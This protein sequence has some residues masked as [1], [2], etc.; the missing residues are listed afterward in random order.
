MNELTKEEVLHVAHLARIKLSDEEIK[1]YQK[2]LKV[3]MDQVDKIK[4]ISS[5]D[6]ELM[7][8]TFSEECELTKDEEGKMLE[9]S[10]ALKNCK[11]TVGNYIEVPV[12]IN[13]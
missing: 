11:H 2:D 12:M 7:F 1:K 8:S 6:D 9:P 5:F 10:E 3:L 13:E 4:D